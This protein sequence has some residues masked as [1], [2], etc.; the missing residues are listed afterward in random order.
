MVKGALTI[1][2]VTKS[3]GGT[4]VCRAQNILGSVSV[5]AQLMIFSPLRVSIRPPQEV[6]PFFGSTLRLP[7]EAESDPRPRVTWKRDGKSSLP[8]NSFVLQN[9]TLVVHTKDFTP[10]KRLML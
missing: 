6:T 9:G 7:C 1:C 4:Y 3:N 5:A 2:K 8:V 10:V